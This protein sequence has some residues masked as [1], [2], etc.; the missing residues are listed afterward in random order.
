MPFPPL[1]FFSLLSMKRLMALL[2]NFSSWGSYH[3]LQKFSVPLMP[4][5]ALWDFKNFTLILSEFSLY[6]LHCTQKVTVFHGLPSYIINFSLEI[7]EN[8]INSLRQDI[9]KEDKCFILLFAV[10]WCP[11]Q[12][13]YI[14]SQI[15]FPWPAHVFLA[16][17]TALQYS[18][19]NW[20]TELEWQ[21]Q[22]TDGFP[23][24]I[25]FR[26]SDELIQSSDFRFITSLAQHNLV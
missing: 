25:S 14:Y 26:L 17:A 6:S 18:R 23:T 8:Q 16:E 20:M 12:N 15:V 19:P 21:L 3:I 13:N 10:F 4:N 24:V 9:S 2:D 1:P 22:R 11:C 5:E 7:G